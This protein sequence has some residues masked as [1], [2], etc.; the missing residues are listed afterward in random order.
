[1]DVNPPQNPPKSMPK[2]SSFRRPNGGWPDTF[3][4]PFLICFILRDDFW[5]PGGEPRKSG[6]AHNTAQK[7]KYAYFLAPLA[8]TQ[9]PKS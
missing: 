6:L 4:P 8:A 7:N 2:S 9:G 3:R 1:M 5:D